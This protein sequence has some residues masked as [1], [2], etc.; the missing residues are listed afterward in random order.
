MSASSAAIHVCESAHE[1]A[2]H[3]EHLVGAPPTVTGRIGAK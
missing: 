3:A 1:L 2:D